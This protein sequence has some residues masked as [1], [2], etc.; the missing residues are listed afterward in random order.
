MQFSAGPST[1]RREPAWSAGL[2]A[3]RLRRAVTRQRRGGRGAG[4]SPGGFASLGGATHLKEK[5]SADPLPLPRAR[6]SR[7][8]GGARLAGISE[9]EPYQRRSKVLSRERPPRAA[10][11]AARRLRGPAGA[12][13]EATC[14]LMHAGPGIEL[15]PGPG[16]GGAVGPES[17]GP[18]A[19]RRVRTS[20]RPLA[21]EPR[22]RSH[23]RRS[24]SSGNASAAGPRSAAAS[25]RLSDALLARGPVGPS[26]TSLTRPDTRGRTAVERTLAAPGVP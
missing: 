10:A 19:A 7:A 14:H 24:A 8:L 17:A 5:G 1:T 23:G 16:R 3:A 2:R 11:A 21:A 4:E 9:Q 12:G 20:H 22:D 26:C 18:W 13:A 15:I 25:P 6:P